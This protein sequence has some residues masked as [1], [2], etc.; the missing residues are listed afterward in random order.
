MG[1]TTLPSPPGIRL[2]SAPR[3]VF[4]DSL[5][6]RRPAFPIVGR[7]VRVAGRR[8]QCHI[9]ARGGLAATERVDVVRGTVDGVGIHHWATWRVRGGSSSSLIGRSSAALRRDGVLPLSFP[10]SRQVYTDI[11]PVQAPPRQSVTA[12]DFTLRHSGKQRVRALGRPVQHD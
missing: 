2:L 7:S 3:R 4:A 11:R 5:V 10:A 1:G 9:V 12:D 6:P 8:K